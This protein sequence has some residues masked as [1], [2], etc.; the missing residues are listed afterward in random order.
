MD[1]FRRVKRYL[2][3]EAY[4]ALDKRNREVVV[5]GGEL[6]RVPTHDEQGRELPDPVPLAPP[7]GWHA[8]PS[9]FDVMRDMIRGEHL[10]AFAESQGSE[11]WEEAQDFDVGEDEFPGSP[12]EG[13]FE[14][15]EDL[16]E[17]RQANFRRRFIEE[18]ENVSYQQWRDRVIQQQ[19]DQA[20]PFVRQG[21]DSAAEGGRKTLDEPVKTKSSKGRSAATDDHSSAD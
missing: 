17:R 16:Q 1:I 13:E 10:K 21:R 8:Q 6:A 18:E 4:A 19:T 5:E 7:V 20:G 9:M 2:S 14:P 12:Y 11:T 15:L 3:P